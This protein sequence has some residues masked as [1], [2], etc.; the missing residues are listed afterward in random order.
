MEKRTSPRS[1]V[2]VDTPRGRWIRERRTLVPFLAAALRKAAPKA[3][4]DVFLISRSQMRAMNRRF[5]RRD[6]PTTVLSFGATL[7]FPAPRQRIS[8]GEVYLAP[9]VIAERRMDIRELALHGLLHLLGY[10]HDGKRDTIE[11]EAR[12][13]KLLRTLARRPGEH[14]VIRHRV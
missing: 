3:S 8:L 14:G 5:L 13:Q 1:T 2:A 11:M 4:V 9:D 12:E 10:T 7:G 6:R